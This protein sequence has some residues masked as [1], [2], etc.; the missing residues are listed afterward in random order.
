VGIRVYKAIPN[1]PSRVYFNGWDKLTIKGRVRLFGVEADTPVANPP[2]VES[3]YRPS[4]TSGRPQINIDNW[5]PSF[6]TNCRLEDITEITCCV[7]NSASHRRIYGMLLRYTNGRRACVG[8]YRLN[9]ASAPLTVN[10]SKP[11]TIG[12]SKTEEGFP[13]VID[14]DLEG[15]SEPSA[16][17]IPQMNVSWSEGLAPGSI[18]RMQI[19]WH[20]RLEWWFG[21]RG[22][23]IRRSS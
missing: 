19:P 10:P 3:G 7:D 11:L 23:G 22:C 2:I 20:G 21:R 12:M 6:Y 1:S 8:Q 17:T 5:Y 18:R 15:L 13:Y 9:W 4:W 14:V 16:V